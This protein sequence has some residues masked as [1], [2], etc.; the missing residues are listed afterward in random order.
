MNENAQPL[1]PDELPHIHDNAPNFQAPRAA[2]KPRALQLD[3]IIAKH[4]PPCVKQVENLGD[5]QRL[6]P[7]L[8]VQVI[9]LDVPGVVV[10]RNIIA[11]PAFL[12]NGHIVATG[13]LDLQEFKQF[14]DSLA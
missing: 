7:E 13:N 9:D 11:V 6:L 3:I 14:V 8:A 10:P 4:C 1:A 5:L 2:A 12:L